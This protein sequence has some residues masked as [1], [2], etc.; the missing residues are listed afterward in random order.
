MIDVEKK[1]NQVKDGFIARGVLLKDRNMFYTAIHPTEGVWVSE[2]MYNNDIAP[3]G[4][5][6]WDNIT[7]VD[8]DLKRK[9]LFFK[10]KDEQPIL[11]NMP[12]WSEADPKHFLHTMHDTGEQAVMIDLNICSDEFVVVLSTFFEIGNIREPKTTKERVSDVFVKI[13]EVIITLVAIFVI[14]GI[15]FG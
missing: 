12:T 6:E 9:L 11:D 14:L 1:Y 3:I 7:G 13:F 15:I 5:V 10:I 2:K 8:I 4:F